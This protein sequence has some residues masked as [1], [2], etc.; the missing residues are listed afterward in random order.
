MERDV[1]LGRIRNDARVR[2]SRRRQE[3]AP[4]AGR[5]R[6]PP[7][8][9]TGSAPQSEEPLSEPTELAGLIEYQPGRVMT[10][11][12]F[13]ADEGLSEQSTPHDAI[14]Q[15]RKGAL[16]GEITGVC[17]GGAHCAYR[18]RPPHALIGAGRFKMLLTLLKNPG[19]PT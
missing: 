15:I 2:G 18:R 12:A 16:T 13:D 6:A 5:S 3:S 14:V 19:T 8:H 7:P 9:R 4:H 1:H 10:L 11:F 17:T